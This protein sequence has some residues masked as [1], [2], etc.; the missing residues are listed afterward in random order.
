METPQ[1]ILKSYINENKSIKIHEL[2]SENTDELVSVITTPDLLSIKEHPNVNN[3][4][5][6]IQLYENVSKELIDLIVIL[7]RHGSIN[8][9]ESHQ[10]T[11]KE[12]LEKLIFRELNEADGYGY[13]WRH[14]SN[15]P[16]MLILYAINISLMKRKAYN[17]LNEIMNMPYKLRF[18]GR[19]FMDSYDITLP[20]AMNCY[21]LFNN[22]NYVNVHIYQYLPGQESNMSSTQKYL[23]ANTRVYKY[24]SGIISPYFV[25]ES[26][27]DQYFDLYE[28]FLGLFIMDKRL[29]RTNKLPNRNIGEFAPYGR[30]YWMFSES[31]RYYHYKDSIVHKFINETEN[32]ENKILESG[33]F[34][35]KKENFEL[36][37]QYYKDLLQRL[38]GY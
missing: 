28:Y 19:E 17:F 15:Y 6:L 21:H 8:S 25:N 3:I 23:V 37:N 33:F 35:G 24:L 22:I 4:G 1:E 16:L 27:F 34:R 13:I 2:L 36:A 31:G 29:S 10:E 7:I 14:F 38:T 12:V 11:V 30:K 20:E 18:M 5:N 26:D 9:N 32:S